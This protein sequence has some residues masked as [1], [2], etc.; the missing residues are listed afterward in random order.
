M[1][2]T[3]MWAGLLVL[4]V[5]SAVLTNGTEEWQVGIGEVEG[6]MD[7]QDYEGPVIVI[8]SVIRYRCVIDISNSGA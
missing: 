5:A 3:L 4:V 7:H 2:S 8:E 1:E 6:E